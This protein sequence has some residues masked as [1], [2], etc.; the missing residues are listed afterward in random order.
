MTSERERN[1]KK[2]RERCLSSRS[3]QENMMLVSFTLTVARII[4]RVV[5]LVAS[6]GGNGRKEGFLDNKS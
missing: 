2:K 6:Y 1:K 3:L 4:S 5:Y